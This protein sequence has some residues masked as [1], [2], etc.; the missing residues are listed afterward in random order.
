[1]KKGVLHTP[2]SINFR[3]NINYYPVNTI[4]YFEPEDA[5]APLPDNHKDPVVVGSVVD[6]PL[7]ITSEPDMWKDPLESNDTASIDPLTLK[8]VV[9]VVAVVA[10]VA[11]AAVPVALP[12]SIWAEPDTKDGFP[13]TPE[14]GTAL[15]K[16]AVSVCEA[17]ITW[18]AVTD[19]WASSAN[20]TC[21]ADMA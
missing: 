1:M 11:N 7:K 8:A 3:F 14:N 4:K 18:E 21:E 2:F 19:N 20:S 10:W 16:S 15:A 9:A 17:E 5:P 12:K 6:N 13:L